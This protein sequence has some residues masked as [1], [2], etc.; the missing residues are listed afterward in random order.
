MNLFLYLQTRRV[1]NGLH[2]SFRTPVRAAMTVF[3]AGYLVFTLLALLHVD[4]P[5][6][7][8]PHFLFA[9]DIDNPLALL[10]LFHAL[11]LLYV[12]PPPKYLY[13]IFS[14]TDVAN[15]YPVPLARWRVFRFFL[16][17]RSFLLF[18]VFV[19]IGALYGSIMLRAVLPGLLAPVPQGYGALWT[20]L[21]IACMV[22]AL[23][24]LLCWRLLIDILR[25]FHRIPAM[26]YR[27]AAIVVVGA[28]VAVLLY[29]VRLA[30]VA[31]KHP[32]EGL[33][34]AAESYPLVLLLAPFR[35]LAELLLRK[36]DFSSP[37]LWGGLVFW[38]GLA[39]SGYQALKRQSPLLYEYAA[40]LASFR[41]EM[42]ARLRN[43]AAA[44][45]E[46]A[47][48]G[49]VVLQAPWFLR[50]VEPR[51]A[52][53]IFWR[54]TLVAWRS[55]G[56]VVRWLHNLLLAAIVGAWFAVSWYHAPLAEARIRTLGSLLLM[57]CIVPLTMISISSIAEILKRVEIQKP[58]PVGKLQTVSMHILQWTT[59]ICLI[60]VPPFAAAA[61]L[62][63]QFWHII[64]FLLACGCSFAHVSVSSS[65]VVALFNPDQNDP[66]QRLYSGFFGMFAMIGSAL[67]AGLILVFGFLLHAPM[68]LILFL[69]ILANAS[70]AAFLHALSARKYADFV[71]TE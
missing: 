28:V 1:K 29:H 6:P 17:T 11:V 7:K 10:T 15:F 46:R 33:V 68:V 57:L 19:G 20:I 56:Q 58:L 12:L 64:L 54:D 16:L 61:I 66:V 38:F 2:R 13:T 37:A 40:R 42:I 53:A 45:K 30:V 4:S 70:V 36:T 65:F 63:S 60:F 49:K 69:V 67:P 41:T 22:V 9:L 50:M 3:I 25:E 39:V 35:I 51:R 59:M 47:A 31:G 21:Y 32:V 44:I 24:G 48:K 18:Y 71:F 34:V 8:P 23:A 52:G 14:E 26:L 5:G 62:F 55:Y 27:T 43:P